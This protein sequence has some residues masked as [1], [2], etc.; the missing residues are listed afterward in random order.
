MA[1]FIGA[2]AHSARL[3]RMAGSEM[4][5]AVFQALFA[6]GNRIETTAERSITA[7]SVSGAGHVASQPGEAPNADTR[8][9]DTSIET[10]G[11]RAVMKVRVTSNAPYSADLE[12]GTSKMA[13]RPFMG[14]AA[15]K[16]RSAATE[17][18]RKA[19]SRVSRKGA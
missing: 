12:L 11:D 2:K 17:L 18:V 13:A 10:T 5:D 16:E 14:P 15:R 4:N 9:L 8:L 1:K 3:A 19:V 7:G 6:A